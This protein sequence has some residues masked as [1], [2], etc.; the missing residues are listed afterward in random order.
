[1]SASIT[2]TPFIN[3][4]RTDDPGGAGVRFVKNHSSTDDDGGGIFEWDASSTL[5]DNDGTIIEVDEVATGR[6][7][8]QV[9]VR[10]P[11]HAEWFGAKGDGSTNDLAAIQACLDEFGRVDL[12]AKTYVIDTNRIR[13]RTNDL[14]Q[15]QGIDMT[16]I[17][18]KWDPTTALKVEAFYNQNYNT[19]TNDAAIRDLTVDCWFNSSSR[20][21]TRS[22]VLLRGERN[23]VERVKVVNFGVGIDRN[24]QP[25]PTSIGECFVI[26]LWTTVAEGTMGTIR[27]CVV[28]QPG[29]HTTSGPSLFNWPE[30]TALTVMGPGDDVMGVGGGILGNRVHDIPQDLTTEGAYQPSS[31]HAITVAACRGTEVRDN[32]VSNCDGAAF[33][34]QSHFDED[35]VVCANRFLNVNIGVYIGIHATDGADSKHTRMRIQDNVILLGRVSAP[36]EWG[37]TKLAVAGVYLFSESGLA[38]LG[39]RF[40]DIAILR[41][42]VRGFSMTEN[43][44]TIYAF[45]VELFQNSLIFENLLVADNTLEVPDHGASAGGLFFGV[46]YEFAIA[47]I[48]YSAYVDGTDDQVR[49]AIRLHRNRAL[50]GQELRLKAYHWSP[51]NKTWA[52]YSTRLQ[53]FRSPVA[54]RAARVY[55]DEFLGQLPRSVLGWADLSDGGGVAAADGE[56]GRPGIAELS[57]G[58]AANKYA[59]LMYHNNGIKLG[60]GLTHV[61]EFSISRV[62]ET[63]NAE[64][65]AGFMQSSGNVGAYFKFGNTTTGGYLRFITNDG[66]GEETYELGDL[67]DAQAK[68][69]RYRIVVDPDASELHVF[70]SEPESGALETRPIFLETCTEH[71]PTGSAL[72]FAFKIMQKGEGINRLLRIDYLQHQVY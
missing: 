6:W 40:K 38:G 47:F 72:G 10:G 30:I 19:P 21:N 62:L 53:R 36:L 34:C 25:S 45:G 18:T 59:M 14:V 52:P 42:Y 16:T 1:M 55:Y 39:M 43:T 37:S 65:R 61:V 23:V 26:A 13:L 49:R 69:F 66:V 35:V 70:R 54:H 64:W 46:P 50:D 7:I 33:Y 57:T 51:A 60:G 3:D 28:T 12:L 5:D 32:E 71:I 17:V 2:Q 58:T 24:A 44:T 29:T 63:S 31:P 68:W 48:P 56:D 20:L 11:C 9:D 22:G 27:E 67:V 15:G 4:L 8:R 41:N